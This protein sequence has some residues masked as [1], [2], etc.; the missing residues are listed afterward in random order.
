MHHTIEELKDEL[1]ARLDIFE[2]L[3][4]LELTERE[5][6]DYLTDYIEDNKEKLMAALS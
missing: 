6:L 2:L 1:A 4:V 3:D 5:L